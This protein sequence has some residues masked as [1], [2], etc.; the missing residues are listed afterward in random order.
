MNLP[1]LNTNTKETTD[2]KPPVVDTSI[3]ANTAALVRVHYTAG[4]ADAQPCNW[5]LMPVE[6]SE[7][8][9][10]GLNSMT[11]STFAGTVAEFNEALRGL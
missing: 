1:D 6:G 9:V 4:S 3:I 8:Q 5:T 2:E 11:G 7:D 10:T